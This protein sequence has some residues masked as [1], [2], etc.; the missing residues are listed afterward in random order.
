MGIGGTGKTDWLIFHQI[1][2]VRNEVD[3]PMYGEVEIDEM[4][5]GKKFSKIRRRKRIQFRAIARKTPVKAE[6][7]E[8]ANAFTLLPKTL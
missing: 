6:V 8:D 4:H 7:V 2:K 5:F 3:G 1:R